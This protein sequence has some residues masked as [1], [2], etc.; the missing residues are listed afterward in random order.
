M[1]GS[2]GIRTPWTPPQE[3]DDDDDDD[4]E[5]EEEDADEGEGPP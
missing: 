3:E 4:D 2:R 1:Q 5:E